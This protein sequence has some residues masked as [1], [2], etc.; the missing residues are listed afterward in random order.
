MAVLELKIKRFVVIDLNVKK[1]ALAALATIA[2]A[3]CGQDKAADPVKD[4]ES[5]VATSNESTE[6]KVGTVSD[7][8]KLGYAL[9]AK[10]AKFIIADTSQ[11]E[12][13]NFN[14]E[15][16]AKGFNDELA[17]KGKMT[18]EEIQ[19]QFMIF[20]QQMQAAQQQAHAAQK[21]QMAA[22][23]EKAKVAGEAYLAENAKKEGVIT[24]ESGLQYS[25]ITAGEKDGAKPKATDVVKVH[26]TG[27]FIDGKKFDSS[28]DRGQPATFGL[29]QVI[30]GWTEGV[31]LMSVGSKYHFVIP[32]DLAY[33]PNGRPG[34][35]PGNS[36]LEFDIELLEINPADK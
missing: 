32:G 30:K 15:A 10:M 11:Y 22:E 25:I 34:S 33:G 14:K 29:N 27:T 18:A 16:V 1:L 19:A 28:V 2:L 31:Q 21:Q 23:A 9:G 20:Q 17:D 26:Y 5:K 35:I 3:G 36:V 7:A 24:T 12:I 4:E 8:D 13:K 6:K